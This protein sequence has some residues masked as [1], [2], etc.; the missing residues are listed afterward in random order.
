MI[1]LK[2]IFWQV[3]LLSPTL[4]SGFRSQ[5]PPRALHD[6]SYI[7]KDTYLAFIYI[8]DTSSPYCNV[9]IMHKEHKTSMWW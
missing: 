1:Q 2:E 8:N 9:F 3:D 7:R 5:G 4:V 6:V